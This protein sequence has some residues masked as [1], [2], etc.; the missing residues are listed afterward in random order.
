MSKHSKLSALVGQERRTVIFAVTTTRTPNV[1]RNRA[2]DMQ[3]C[4]EAPVRL[5]S[6]TR[7]YLSRIYWG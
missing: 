6:V 1:T 7:A 2:L 5:P 4:L 3:A